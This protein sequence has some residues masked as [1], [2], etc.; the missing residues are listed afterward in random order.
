VKPRF[1][2]LFHGLSASSFQG[3]KLTN[4]NDQHKKIARFKTGLFSLWAPKA[5]NSILSASEISSCFAVMSA[6]ALRAHQ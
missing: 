5:F 2:Y 4:T 1:E 3:F 6:M